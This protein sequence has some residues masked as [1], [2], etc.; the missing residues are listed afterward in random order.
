LGVTGGL[1]SQTQGSTGHRKSR[2][3]YTPAPGTEALLRLAT[4]VSS[5]ENPSCAR[6]PAP[7]LPYT[8]LVPVAEVVIASRL[9]HSWQGA[10]H[11]SHRRHNGR[12]SKECNG[13]SHY[14]SPPLVSYTLLFIS[15][16]A[17][18]TSPRVVP[19]IFSKLS[20]KSLRYQESTFPRRHLL[21]SSSIKGER[22]EQPLASPYFSDP[23]Y[24]SA[25]CRILNVF[26]RPQTT[27]CYVELITRID[28]SF[29]CSTKV[30]RRFFS[31]KLLRLVA[32]ST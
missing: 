23:D 32:A 19:N 28:D 21:G 27:N 2:G 29:S 24:V 18:F 30:N 10:G 12:Y 17:L 25:N 7:V 16:R 6:V 11:Y 20:S 1:F 13:A 3:Y 26:H 15:P 22:S 8:T 5:K 31:C 4:A 9:G 14:T